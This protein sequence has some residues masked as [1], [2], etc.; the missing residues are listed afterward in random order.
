MKCLFV[1]ALF[2][3]SPIAHSGLLSVERDWAFIQSVGGIEVARPQVVEGRRILPVNCDVSGAQNFTV[4]PTTI[5][6]ALT[7]AEI[8]SIVK[9]KQ[10][11]LTVVTGL[12]GKSS[13]C[14]AINLDGIKNGSYAVF[15]QSPNGKLNKIGDVKI[16]L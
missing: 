10:I 6:S 2:L 16:D 4:K 14:P 9:E 3:I 8:K 15:Y 11:H 5:N 12:G 7:V 13:K 1:F